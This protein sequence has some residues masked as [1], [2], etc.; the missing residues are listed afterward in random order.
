MGKLIRMDSLLFVGA[1][2]LLACALPARAFEGIYI[3]AAAGV[4]MLDTSSI[5]S[6]G[7]QGSYGDSDPGGKLGLG[8][9]ITEDIAL[10]A[11][12]QTLGKFGSTSPQLATYAGT[13]WLIGGHHLAQSLSVHVKVGPSL[14]YAE[15]GPANDT[16]HG[17]SVGAGLDYR[18]IRNTDISF[19]YERFGA[20]IFRTDT[21]FDFYSIGLKYHF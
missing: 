6:L 18:W 2:A 10:E 7:A 17:I 21:S 20:K 13:L 16:G 9:K 5:A 1:A 11:A 4:V 3:S 19:E 8:L 12:G 15:V 14:Y